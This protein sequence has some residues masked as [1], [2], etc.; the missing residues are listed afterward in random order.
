MTKMTYRVYVT[1]SDDSKAGTNEDVWC[2][3][4][5]TKGETAVCH[6]DIGGY[7]DFEKGDSQ[8]YVIMDDDIGELTHIQFALTAE[9][10]YAGEVS[11]TVAGDF[12][13]A[14]AGVE[15][16]NVERWKSQHHSPMWKL[17]HARVHVY[18]LADLVE[19][20]RAVF[21][22]ER[23]VAPGNVIRIKIGRAHV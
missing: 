11:L 16:G 13:G 3:L 17:D 20:Q 15:F 18:L 5:G 9:G 2:Q 22:A 1:T 14:S 21:T 8:G 4:I 10:S 12:K 23:W 19:V 7:N 6:F